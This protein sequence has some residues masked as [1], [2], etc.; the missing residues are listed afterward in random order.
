MFSLPPCTRA[1]DIEC[2]VLNWAK[3]EFLEMQKMRADW[4][5]SAYPNLIL[6]RLSKCPKNPYI[7]LGVESEYS[8]DT[9][10][11]AAAAY[12]TFSLFI[13]PDKCKHPDAGAAFRSR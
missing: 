2:V 1:A 8:K 13:H 10:A 5:P 7:I 4:G 3:K 11:M 6:S 12:K 9:I